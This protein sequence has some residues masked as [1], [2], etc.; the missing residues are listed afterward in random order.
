MHL[1]ALALIL[2]GCG[3]SGPLSLPEEPPPAAEEQSAP[4]DSGVQPEAPPN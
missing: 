4:E 1:A 3:F 2:S